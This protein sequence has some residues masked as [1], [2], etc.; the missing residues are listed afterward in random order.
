MRVLLLLVVLLATACG[1]HVE[2]G[3]T[4]D[5]KLE[6]RIYCVTNCQTGNGPT[7]SPLVR[8][9][10]SLN[11]SVS[12]NQELCTSFRSPGSVGKTP[13]GCI[14]QPLAPVLITSKLRN[15]GDCQGVTL[16]TEATVLGNFNSNQHSGHYEFCS[17]SGN[18]IWVGIED[19][20]GVIDFNDSQVDITAVDGQILEWHEENGEYLICVSE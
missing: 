9:E 3:V 6:G 16:Y 8:L 17:Q 10:F 20:A 1:K 5:G 14:S 7:L 13:L 15:P 19:H 2:F 11:N 4:G 18:H 12:H